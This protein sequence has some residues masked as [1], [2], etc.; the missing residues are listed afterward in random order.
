MRSAWQLLVSSRLY[1]SF[2]GNF[3]HSITTCRS[4]AQHAAALRGL[5]FA[6]G[7]R[8]GEPR[9]AD[10]GQQATNETHGKGKDNTLRKQFGGDLEGEAQLG[11][12]LKNQS[13][14]G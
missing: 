4:G 2:P 3:L 7:C 11:K 8:H 9:C 5:E 14:S 6:E 1:L 10:G 12:N 13:A